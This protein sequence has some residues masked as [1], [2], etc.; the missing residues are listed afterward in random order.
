MLTVMEYDVI[1]FLFSLWQENMSFLNVE[2]SLIFPKTVVS[3]LVSSY[4]FFDPLVLLLRDSPIS[5]ARRCT[6]LIDCSIGIRTIS[7]SEHG[8]TMSKK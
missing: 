1:R 2:R 8:S 7:V 6:V 3:I 5:V 4:L